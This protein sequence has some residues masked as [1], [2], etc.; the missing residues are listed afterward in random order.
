MEQGIAEV[1]WASPSDIR[2]WHDTLLTPAERD[3]MTEMRRRRDRDRMV[4]G[5]ALLRLTV[6]ATVGVAVERVEI[7][8]SCPDCDTP[9]GKPVVVGHDLHVSV[10][11]SGERIAV[12]LTRSGLVGVDVERTGPRPRIARLH[13]MM[14]SPAEDP[15]EIDF[16]TRWARKEAVLKATGEGL[17]TPMSK[18][19]LT[20]AGLVGWDLPCF[21]HDL[22]P[23]TGYAAALAVLTSQEV[24]VSERAGSE[25]LR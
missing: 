23:G 16:H 25:L 8:R 7:D 20:K 12:A 21:L 5:N 24:A 15:D 13:G 17:R 22:R 3:R 9:H 10:S 2:S 1:W 11:H 6:A 14:L 18:L 19:T 4:V